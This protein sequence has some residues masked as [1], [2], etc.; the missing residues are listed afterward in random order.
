MSRPTAWD[1]FYQYLRRSVCTQVWYLVLLL[2]VS[3][4]SP[5]T[6]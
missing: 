2:F 5:R 1:P 4:I 3:L 6:L